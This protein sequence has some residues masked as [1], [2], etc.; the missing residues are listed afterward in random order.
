M[1]FASLGR[2]IERVAPALLTV[3]MFG[4]VVGFAAIGLSA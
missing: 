3:A 2:L 1:S 4:L